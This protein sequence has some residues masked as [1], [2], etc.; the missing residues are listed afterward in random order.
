[1]TLEHVAGKNVGDI[2][3]YALSTCPWC[4]KAKGLLSGLGIDYYFTD[5]DLLQGK[6]RDQ[7]MAVVRK[8]NPSGSFPTIVINDNR[9]IVGFK[10]LELRE[11]LN[12]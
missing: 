3:I 1:M 2:K 7:A 5:V 11:A 6:E 8:W 10:E 4:K 12:L 9:C